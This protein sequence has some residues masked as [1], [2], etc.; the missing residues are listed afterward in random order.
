[1]GR[2]TPEPVSVIDAVQKR[3]LDA[4]ERGYTGEEVK[5]LAEAYATVKR[6]DAP[7]RPLGSYVQRAA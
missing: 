5:L 1:M 3:L 4:C 7:Q 2:K 6:T